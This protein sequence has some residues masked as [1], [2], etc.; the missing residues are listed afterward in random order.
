MKRKVMCALLCVLL[1]WAFPLYVL[2]DSLPLVVDEADL[3]TQQEE[4]LLSDKALGLRQEYGMDA[5]ILTVPS[6]GG[7]NAMTYAEDYYDNNGYGTDDDRSGTLFLL[8]M[9]ERE[10]YIDT[11][12]EAIYALT[13]YVL[14]EQEELVLPSLQNGDYYGA[15]DAWLD[16]LDGYFEAYE[17]GSPV[18]GFVPEEDRYNEHDEVVY[19]EE[20]EGVDLFLSLVIGLIAGGIAVGVMYAMMNTRHPR[21][22]AV[23]YMKDNS[24]N[25]RVRRDVFLYSQV[26]KTRRETSSGSSGGSGVHKSSSG[27]SHGGRGGKF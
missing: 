25:L 8:A 11:S 14:L 20:E 17:N 19:D 26:S 2:A 21:N 15:I 10:W 7:K 12:G 16:S 3:L 5:V 4:E 6:L 27:R 9:E 13:D 1:L 23:E 18:D 22:S 24:Y